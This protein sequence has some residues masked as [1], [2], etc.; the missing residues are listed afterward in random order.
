MPKAMIFAPCE[1]II[2]A[3]DNSVSMISLFEEI[4]ITVPAD[5]PIPPNAIFPMKWSIMTLWRREE[6]EE[7]IE[8]EEKCELVTEEGKNAIEASVKFKMPTLFNRVIME[9]HGFPLHEGQCRL[10]MSLRETNPPSN[11]R[12]IAEFPLKII[13]KKS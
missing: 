13:C 8:F 4:T 9:I 7:D 3:K 12:E 1:K 2:L 11:W 5:K 6:N 10:S